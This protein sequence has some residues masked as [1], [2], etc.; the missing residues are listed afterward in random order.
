V[1]L[2]VA[3]TGAG[4]V[5]DIRG[6]FESA[7][8]AQLASA[9]QNGAHSDAKALAALGVVVAYPGSGAVGEVPS[10]VAD[11]IEP[12][13]EGST[14]RYLQYPL[15]AATGVIPW[16]GSPSTYQVLF[17]IARE[18]NARACVVLAPD[19]EALEVKP[20]IS[21]TSPIL[22]ERCD[23]VMPIYAMGKYE[24]LLNTGVIAPLNRALYGRRVRFPLAQDFAVSARLLQEFEQPIP[25]TAS[26][27]NALFWPST[28]TA[29]RDRKICQT[30][31][32]VRHESLAEGIDLSTL[33]AQ[34]IAP[35]FA[36][37][38]A[39]APVWQRVRGSHL[40]EMVGVASSPTNDGTAADIRPMLET[41]NL[42]S[43]NLQEVW[44]LVLPPV[45]LLEIK[46]LAGM[47]PEAFSMPDELWV[48]IVYD[49]ALAYRLRSMNRSHLMGAFMPLY[50]G[51]V[52]SHVSEVGR[53]HAAHEVD[54]RAERLA[55]T[56]EEG[57]PYLLSR[58]RWPDRFNP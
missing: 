53:M 31:I 49:F 22:A 58:W 15:P 13:S 32:G 20:L 10:N 33:L 30:H 54:A 19:L 55:R 9:L 26:Q 47:S 24:G 6:R 56:Y 27:A 17:S 5:H 36:D 57:K 3:V 38:E 48:R 1:D 34:T 2:L 14:V 45:T 8:S 50:L 23:L 18:L 11:R 28:E 46:R 21:L 7:L 25:K 52:A 44:G 40:P 51:W 43:R 12:G 42:A 37:M 35:L 39:N 16:L 41:F 29:L 4:S